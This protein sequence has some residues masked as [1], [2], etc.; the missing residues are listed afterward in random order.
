MPG[1]G[2]GHA[3]RRHGY[4][5]RMSEQKDEATDDVTSDPA[6]DDDTGHDWSTEGGATEQGPATDT[7]D[8]DDTADDAD[9]EGETTGLAEG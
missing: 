8:T 6:H 1:N 2:S 4:C 7:D 5:L 3:S 9:L